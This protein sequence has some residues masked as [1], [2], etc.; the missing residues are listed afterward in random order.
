MSVTGV[1]TC[2]LGFADD[3]VNAAVHAA[4]DRGSMTTL[5]CPED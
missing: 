5:N 1:G 3:D 4:V 2:A